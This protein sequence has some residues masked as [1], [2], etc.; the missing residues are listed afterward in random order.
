MEHHLLHM[1]LCLVLG[2]LVADNAIG[3]PRGGLG[4]A[5]PFMMHF[6][7]LHSIQTDR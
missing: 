4:H 1:S 2:M 6:L 7:P 5:L 3:L